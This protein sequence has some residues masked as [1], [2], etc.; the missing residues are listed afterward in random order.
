MSRLKKF[1]HSLFSGYLQLG[2]NVVFSLAS[3]PLALSYLSTKEFGLWA[4]TTQVATFVGQLDFGMS[5]SVSR[6][7]VDHKD[8]RD[9]GDYGSVIQTGIWVS[10]VQGLLILAVG[11]GLAFLIGPAMK[12]P[13]ELERDF[14]WLMI[15]QCGLMAGMFAG[16]VFSLVLAAHQRYDVTNYSQVV[17]FFV[18]LGLMWWGFAAGLGVFS[19]LW[20]QLGTLALSTLVA[21]GACVRLQL[22]PRAGH[23][24]R[25]NRRLFREIFAFGA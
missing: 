24:G 19:L 18:N 13:A 2:A 25:P 4:L 12:V 11:V 3:V 6:V 10:V 23:W 22:L 1:A 8:Q 16:R 7:L 9:A 15:G 17:A 20:A 14:R 5:S 21:L